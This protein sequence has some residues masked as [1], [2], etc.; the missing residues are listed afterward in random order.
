MV[1]LPFPRKYFWGLENV[2]W[3]QQANTFGKNFPDGDGD[4]QCTPP[5]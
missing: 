3:V 5:Y 4:P 1:S 2:K